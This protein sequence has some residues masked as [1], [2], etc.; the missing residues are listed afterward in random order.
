[1][2]RVA[3]EIAEEV[4]VLLKH[5]HPAPG[6]REQQSRHHPSGAATG[7]DKVEV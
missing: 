6:T 1:V 4:G 3:A 7:D 5:A 2:N